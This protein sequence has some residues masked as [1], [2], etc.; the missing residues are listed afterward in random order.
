M[1]IKPIVSSLQ[2][3][4]QVKK[5]MQWLKQLAIETLHNRLAARLYR[6]LVLERMRELVKEYTS[7]FF[8]H[9]ASAGRGKIVFVGEIDAF[10]HVL[11]NSITVP[12]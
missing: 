3:Y 2:L 6:W 5:D 7:V 4:K 8:S 12:Y 11:I 9:Y 10:V 1:E